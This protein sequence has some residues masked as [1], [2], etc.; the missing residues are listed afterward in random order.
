M[1]SE[2]RLTVICRNALWKLDELVTEFALGNQTCMNVVS[3]FSPLTTL[4][5]WD[6]LN[7]LI[8]S[9]SLDETKY[10]AGDL[11]GHVGKN[12]PHYKRVHGV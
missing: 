1:A 4:T 9:C 8:Q 11:N 5:F 7:D 6:K 2:L 12:A 3:V 10:I